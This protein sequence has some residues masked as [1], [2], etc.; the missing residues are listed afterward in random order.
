LDKL[1]D[2]ATWVIAAL[3][4]IAGLVVTIGLA[5]LVIGWIWLG[6]ESVWSLIL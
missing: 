6:V 4:I 3:I 2:V 5:A 1:Y